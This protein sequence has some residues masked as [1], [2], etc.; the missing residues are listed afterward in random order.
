MD[1]N[2]CFYSQ[3][4]FG[5]EGLQSKVHLFLIHML[6]L[7]ALDSYSSRVAS[8]FSKINDICILPQT[9]CSTSLFM[10]I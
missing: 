9:K 5:K 6:L 3:K 1:K 4:Y 8:L 7:L 2:I 10:P